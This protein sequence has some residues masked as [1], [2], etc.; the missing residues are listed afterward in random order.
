MYYYNFY[1]NYF[2]TNIKEEKYN[3]DIDIGLQN[4]SL[5]SIENK[6]NKMH[7]YDGINYLCNLIEDSNYEDRLNQYIEYCKKKKRKNSKKFIY[8][9]KRKI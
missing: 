3:L 8:I 9:K 7:I 1:N 2:M 6:S 4:L 5:N